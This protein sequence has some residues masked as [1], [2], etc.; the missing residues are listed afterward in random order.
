MK[1]GLLALLL[2]V[3]LVAPVFAVEKGSMEIVPKVGY[4]IEPLLMETE[5][6]ADSYAYNAE[7]TFSLGADFYYYVV[8]NLGLGAGINHIFT[9][10]LN[11]GWDDESKVGATNIYLSVKPVF[12]LQENKFI[13]K[14]YFLGQLGYGMTRFED[15]WWDSSSKKYN[16]NGLYWAIGAGVEKCNIVVELVYSVNYF[17][18]EDWTESFTNRRTAINAGYKFSI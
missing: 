7:S 18:I 10:N 3:A 16:E 1:K 11:D 15:K 4:V 6:D 9:S 17:E 5:D 13:D 12:E 2:T 14:I 8:N